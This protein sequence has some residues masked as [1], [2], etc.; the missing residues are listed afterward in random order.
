MSRRWNFRAA[1]DDLLEVV[2]NY[3]DT[4]R[5]HVSDEDEGHYL[6]VPLSAIPSLMEHLQSAVEGLAA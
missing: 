1:N 6:D 4:V 2:T 3:D 5:F